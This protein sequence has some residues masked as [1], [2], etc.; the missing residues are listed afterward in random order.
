MTWADFA[1]IF[2]ALV[3]ALMTA[4]GLMVRAAIHLYVPRLL[5]LLEMHTKIQLTNQQRE[6]IEG[7]LQTA[8]GNIETKLQQG[9]L[10]L[11]QIKPTDPEMLAAARAAL[12]R[13]P[14][15]TAAVGI[16]PEVAATVIVGKADTAKA[17]AAPVAELSPP[18]GN[19]LI[20]GSFR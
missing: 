14:A 6:A 8:A 4:V 7:A 9:D 17:L 11:S 3:A 12:S 15:A 19:T 16:T 5:D 20:K 10:Q 18:A 13:V 1:P 2:A